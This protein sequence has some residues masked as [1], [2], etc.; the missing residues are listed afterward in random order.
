M[1]RICLFA[2]LI[3]GWLG[4]CVNAQNE[5]PPRYFQFRIDCGHGNWQ[6]TS[7]IAAAT[8]SLLIADFYAELE[9]P[10]HQRKL[11]NGPLAHGDGGHNRNGDHAFEWHFIPDAWE[12]SDF[13]FEACSGCPFTDLDADPVYWVDSLGNFCPW[14]ARPVREVELTTGTDPNPPLSIPSQVYPNPVHA[15]LTVDLLP[16]ERVDALL[17]DA[18][19][20]AV[21]E[22]P[23]YGTGNRINLLGL[24]TGLYTLELTAPGR[25]RTEHKIFLQ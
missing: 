13:A 3:A 17:R 22:L 21:M 11:I 24:P 12:L 4:S 23:L 15:T 25:A 9:K 19:G 2:L 5:P 20:R 16:M 10:F 14:S 6:D 18:L 7:V 8:D 1:K